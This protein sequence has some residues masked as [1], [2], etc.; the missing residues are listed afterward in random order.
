M[1][2]RKS[3]KEALKYDQREKKADC[4][5][6]TVELA[7]RIYKLKFVRVIPRKHATVENCAVKAKITPSSESQSHSTDGSIS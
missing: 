4:T 2:L 3:N 6:F 5:Y 1:Y 7:H